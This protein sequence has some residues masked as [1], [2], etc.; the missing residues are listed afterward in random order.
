MQGTPTTMLLRLLRSRDASLVDQGVQLAAALADPQMFDDL[1]GGVTYGAFGSLQRFRDR[2]PRW[3]FRPNALFSGGRAH[4]PWLDRAL[5]GLIAL[6]PP[7]S[8]VAARLRGEVWEL[9]VQ[10]SEDQE[11]PIDPSVLACFP[12]LESLQIHHARPL[13]HLSRMGALPRL[14]R[15][16]LHA[17]VLPCGLQGLSAPAL[18]E[19][20]LLGLPLDSLGGITGAPNLEQLRLHG[21]G[22]CDLG[23][24]A[25]LERLVEL[26]IS[27]VEGRLPRLPRLEELHLHGPVTA[28]I[29][30]MEKLR[31][32]WL[33]D[34][35]LADFPMAD[36][37][38]A[39]PGFLTDLPSLEELHLSLA[40]HRRGLERPIFGAGMARLAR[41]T[42][43]AEG[44]CSLAGL[45]PDE[46]GGLPG[47]RE[48][49][50]RTGAALEDGALGALT[51]LRRLWLGS[52][53]QER[54]QELPPD[55]EELSLHLPT[56]QT[57]PPLPAQ[58]RRLYLPGC[59]SLTALDLGGLSALEQVSVDGCSA[60]QRIG[61]TAGLGRLQTL[62][63]RGTRSLREAPDLDGLPELRGVAIE[64]CALSRH[65]FSVA[66]RV[67]LNS[68]PLVDLEAIRRG[69]PP[70][71]EGRARRGTD[72]NSFQA[73]LKRLRIRD[74][75]GID[76]AIADLAASLEGAPDRAI[77]VDRL[78][79]GALPGPRQSS[80]SR[81]EGVVLPAGPLLR[82][83]RN[84]GPYREHATR[85]LLQI[86]PI[87]SAEAERLRQ[88]VTRLRVSGHVTLRRDPDAAVD[89]RPL[90]ALPR[91]TT[92]SVECARPLLGQEVLAQLPVL[93]LEL[94]GC[95][96]IPALPQLPAGLRQLRLESLVGLRHLGGLEGL[97]GLE[98]LELDRL[99]VADLRA[100][101]HLPQL[102]RL[103]LRHLPE[104]ESL[105]GIAGCAGL[106]ELEL[107]AMPLRDLGQ[108]VHLGRLRRLTLDGCPAIHD[109]GPLADLPLTHVQL[110]RMYR[111]K[112]L[113]PL[114][115]VYSLQSVR[116]DGQC[117]AAP[118][119]LPLITGGEV[120]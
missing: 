4:Q 36:F 13:G 40:P 6:A 1:L 104:M 52:P 34:C 111:V 57:L 12:G 17:C 83:N 109:L 56:L 9:W 115:R 95:E 96:G 62:D 70:L 51:G 31:R 78:L 106:E 102:R 105:A 79:S 116:T 32:L 50:V 48:L 43:E 65:N 39:D 5:I 114:C 72:E 7:E 29:A 49:E 61:G 120:A 8:A 45:L 10:G 64:G 14:R 113:R 108:L 94:A 82:G 88:E 55:L 100:L 110:Y 107:V 53:V 119:G 68:D 28:P 19:L 38:M 60:L 47:L 69:P 99:E 91:L 74:L 20:G 42:M 16:W 23:A 112:D 46:R 81:R 54:L 24:L 15:L 73:L 66:V 18:T 92:L 27:G 77:W 84:D 101:G 63:L 11:M 2:D 97:A 80:W 103:R 3:I 71:R 33:A 89:L 90:A 76:A 22:A 87:G 86:A 25:S 35:P 85:A 30:G 117:G 26:S 75:A 118:P 93:N 67:L 58:L 37:P 41:L 21:S 44:L 59:A 98:E